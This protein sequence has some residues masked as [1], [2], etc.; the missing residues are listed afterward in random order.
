M[1]VKNRMEFLLD[2]N[3]QHVETKQIQFYCFWFTDYCFVF[4]FDRWR[5]TRTFF[6]DT[7]SMKFNRYNL[8]CY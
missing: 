5:P 3:Y 6:P 2:K 4:F 7:K 8:V 1:A